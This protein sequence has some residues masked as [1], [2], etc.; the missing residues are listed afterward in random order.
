M[1]ASSPVSTPHVV[2]D[3]VEVG[4][5]VGHREVFEP[6]AEDESGVCEQLVVAEGAAALWRGLRSW[7]SSCSL[8]WVRLVLAQRRHVSPQTVQ[9]CCE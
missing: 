6:A 8:Q 2:G 1:R 3:G 5:R 7:C 9:R 4:D